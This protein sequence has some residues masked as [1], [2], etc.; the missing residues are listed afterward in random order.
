MDV[1]AVG[2]TVDL[3]GAKLNEFQKLRIDAQALYGVV[4]SQRSFENF[5]GS[6]PRIE[7]DDS[8]VVFVHAS[9][10]TMQTLDL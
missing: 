5:G 8:G 9:M 1:H 2:A 10:L 4:E 7:T 3:R 6:F